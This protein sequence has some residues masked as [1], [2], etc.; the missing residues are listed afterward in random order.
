MSSVGIVKKDY[1][2][3]PA[4]HLWLRTRVFLQEAQKRREGKGEK[5]N[6]VLSYLVRLFLDRISRCENH[7]LRVVLKEWESPGLLSLPS[8]PD[9][10]INENFQEEKPL[11]ISDKPPSVCQI[12]LGQSGSFATCADSRPSRPI[13]PSFCLPAQPVIRAGAHMKRVARIICGLLW[14]VIR[15]EQGS[16]G[17]WVPWRSYEPSVSA[18]PS[19]LYTVA[20]LVGLS[21]S[22][23]PINTNP[24][25]WS[26]SLG[27]WMIPDSPMLCSYF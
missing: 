16:P 19:R 13:L 26:L 6:S 23:T 18:W 7:Y 4:F 11:D 21:S 15:R 12:N 5:E 3:L 14:S 25:N 24:R 8:H 27:P 20:L 1:R 22:P 17:T 9:S 2:S 10:Q